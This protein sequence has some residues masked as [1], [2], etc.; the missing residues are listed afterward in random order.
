M[1]VA[2]SIEINKKARESIVKDFF[3]LISSFQSEVFIKNV[4][5]NNIK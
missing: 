3:N 5:I 2:A 1:D 4:D